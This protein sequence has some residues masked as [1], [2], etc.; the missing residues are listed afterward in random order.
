MFYW[1]SKKNSYTITQIQ[2]YKAK[3]NIYSL[4]FLMIEREIK[5]LDIDVKKTV[6]KLEK[7]WAKKTFEGVLVDHYYSF[8]EKKIR[9]RNLEDW[10]VI[11][12]LKTKLNEW[13]DIKSAIENEI[14]VSKSQAEKIVSWRGLKYERSK[15]KRR[16][17]YKIKNI[18]FDIDFYPNISPLLEIEAHDPKEIFSWKKKLFGKKKSKTFWAKKLHQ[19]YNVSLPQFEVFETN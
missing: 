3:E 9:L 1:Q 8:W 5:I 4:L 17:S 12:C 15:C 13:K 14:L 7:F 2:K 10:N 19:Y 18:S 11:V 6:K 16:M